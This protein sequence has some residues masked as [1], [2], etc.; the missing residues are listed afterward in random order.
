MTGPE[1]YLGRYASGG[2]SEDRC[3]E[4]HA[5]ADPRAPEDPIAR[6]REETSLRSLLLLGLGGM[7]LFL[8]FGFFLPAVLAEPSLMWVSAVLFITGASLL[9]GAWFTK[10]RAGRLIICLE[11]SMHVKCEYCGGINDRGQHRCA[12]CGAPLEEAAV[13]AAVI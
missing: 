2:S 1:R 6:V 10:V 13:N 7:V 8:S 11:E 5:V 4:R 9:M 12:F 3:P